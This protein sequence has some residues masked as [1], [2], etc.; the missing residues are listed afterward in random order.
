MHNEL[1]N[2]LPIDRQQ[3]L[4]RDYFLR[5]GTVIALAVTILVCSSIVLLVPTYVFLIK[6]ADAKA[7]RLASLE[8][9]LSSADEVEISARLATLSS[10]ASVLTKFAKASSVSTIIRTVLAVPRPGIKIFGM[11][12][13]PIVGKK[14]GIITISGLSATRDALRSYQLA[15]QNAPFV[16]AAELPI[17]VYAKDADIP[18]TVTITL[19]L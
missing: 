12:H 9:R 19:A 11:T 14:Q 1:T 3:R 2:L 16:S 7:N 8:S 6:S 4:R 10:N 13:A 15:L 5:L 17:S 18:F